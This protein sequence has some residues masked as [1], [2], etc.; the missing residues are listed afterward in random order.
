M[1]ILWMAPVARFSLVLLVFLGAILV[2]AMALARR[3]F[4]GHIRAL[5]LSLE[6]AP[7]AHGVCANLPAE[8]L[9]LAKRF[10]VSTG[11]GGR[12]V[13]VT[14]T[15]EMRPKPGA[16]P[17]AFT[18]RQTTA[19]AEVGFL[20]QAWFRMAGL[21][22]RVIDY[23]VGGVGG[24]EGRL[25][26]ALP[27]VHATGSDGTFRGEAMR[28]LGELMWNPD[29]LLFNPQLAWR[30][31]D[32]RTLEVATG[33]GLRRCEV[34]LVLDD[35]GDPIAMEADS[36]PRVVDG[37]ITTC[38]WVCRCSDYQTIGDRRIPTRGEAGWII[39]SVE[40]VYWRGRIESWA[41]EF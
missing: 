25:L 15:G 19:V 39:D 28:Y 29:G 34:R 22:L 18:A 10:G 33:S 8:V 37:V 38:P 7:K 41:E 14:Q 5:R 30:V 32:A 9:A 40:F 2:G 17:L 3:R 36:R 26:D 1:A 20:W 13:H 21:S 12:L 11:G 35:S 23:V 24:L 27:V 6:Q 4:L 16:K 31:I